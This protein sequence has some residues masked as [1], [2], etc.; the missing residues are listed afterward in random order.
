M[1]YSVGLMPNIAYHMRGLNTLLVKYV[2]RCEISVLLNNLY[3]ISF[4]FASF[5]LVI[6][7]KYGISVGYA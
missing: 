1:F 5:D 4:I 7:L 6:R 2:K 3:S